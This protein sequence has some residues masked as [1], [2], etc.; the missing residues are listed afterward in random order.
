M[1]NRQK[2]TMITFSGGLEVINKTIEPFNVL[3][4]T[5][6]G[7]QLS[8]RAL[9]SHILFALFLSYFLC[10]CYLSAFCRKLRWE[11]LFTT[12]PLYCDGGGGTTSGYV[13]LHD[14]ALLANRS[15]AELSNTDAAR[16]QDFTIE[17]KWVKTIVCGRAFH[18]FLCSWLCV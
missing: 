18:T 10:R 1:T 8:P 6:K 12:I 7:L 3:P 5:W 14:G 15:A 17:I 2:I 9:F 4:C 13:G 11:V 16:R